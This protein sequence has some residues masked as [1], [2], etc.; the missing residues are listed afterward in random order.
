MRMKNYLP[1]NI[2]LL[3]IIGLLGAFLF[4][5]PEP[6]EAEVNPPVFAGW[7]DYN[8]SSAGRPVFT[9]PGDWT[10]DPGE[11]LWYE[12]MTIILGGDLIIMPTGNLTL[13]NCTVWLTNAVDLANEILVNSGGT[14][15]A[16][17][18]TFEHQGRRNDSV[19]E[20]AWIFHVIEIAEETT[21][22]HAVNCSFQAYPSVVFEVPAAES[23][24]IID[25]DDACFYHCNVD[26]AEQ[27][28]SAGQVSYANCRVIGNKSWGGGIETVNFISYHAITVH[29]N[30]TNSLTISITDANN[31][32]VVVVNE[33]TPIGPAIPDW[34]PRF[35]YAPVNNT[36]W[37]S[38][39]NYTQVSGGITNGTNEY[40]FLVN[41][42]YGATWS[43]HDLITLKEYHPR[44]GSLDR[45]MDDHNRSAAS[46]S[47]TEQEEDN[48]SSYNL[49]TSNMTVNSTNAS[50]YIYSPFAINYSAVGLTDA[51]GYVDWGDNGSYVLDYVTLDVAL[52]SDKYLYRDAAY[53]ITPTVTHENP[54]A[55]YAWELQLNGDVLE[56]GSSST[57]S[58]DLDW[59]PGSYD[60]ILNVT[61][62]EG[63]T[64]EDSMVINLRA[65]ATGD[66]DEDDDDD[67][68][69]DDSSSSSSSSSSSTS[70]SSTPSTTGTSVVSSS[71][72]KEWF[73][74]NWYKPYKLK[75]WSGAWDYV[76]EVSGTTWTIIGASSV[77]VVGLFVYIYRFRI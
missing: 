37:F 33:S 20:F 16:F 29:G 60:V 74:D 66:G 8:I 31:A 6:V 32:P 22:V 40:P 75:W 47:I 36:W 45:Y 44:N 13:A 4:G 53:T 76:E 51:D 54:I 27:Y 19:T 77:V 64:A 11:T 55:S 69:D 68:D 72:D 43:D 58:P 42:T 9:T 3:V 57:F 5:I 41:I 61:D 21:V 24:L 73:D 10:I 50:F 71:D 17:N 15:Y 38:Q 46:W 65:R 7:I 39:L 28:Y 62:D 70:T 35:L 12:D 26:M 23:N 52:P 67:D 30:D 63:A 59:N 1:A 49:E 14:L 34:N 56:S 18:S 2:A 48:Y 25:G